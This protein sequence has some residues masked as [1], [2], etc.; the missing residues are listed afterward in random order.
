ME[1]GKWLWCNRKGG[2]K[3]AV[4]DSYE[5]DYS[6]LWEDFVEYVE[7]DEQQADVCSGYDMLSHVD[8]ESDGAFEFNVSTRPTVRMHIC[9]WYWQCRRP[10][11][12]CG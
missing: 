11:V 4:E 1:N 12:H 6:A 10:V 3:R 5:I 7:V 2:G 8:E 9:Y